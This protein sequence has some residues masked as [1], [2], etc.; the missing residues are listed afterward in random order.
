MDG[1]KRA[2]DAPEAHEKEEAK[3]YTYQNGCQ[4]DGMWRSNR[5]HGKGTFKWPSGSS[6]TGEFRNDK[7][8]GQGQIMYADGTKYSGEWRND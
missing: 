1:G 4:Y 5:R 7:R 6:Y 8:H 3:Q 2:D